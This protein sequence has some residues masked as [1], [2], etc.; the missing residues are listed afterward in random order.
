MCLVAF[1]VPNEPYKREDISE[2]TAAYKMLMSKKRSFYI[3]KKK[4]LSLL[5]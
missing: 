5:D 4:D 1:Y 3:K 2:R